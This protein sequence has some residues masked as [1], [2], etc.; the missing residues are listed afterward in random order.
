MLSRRYRDFGR[1]PLIFI[2][3]DTRSKKLN[4]VYQIFKDTLL[5]KY[6]I[7]HIQFNSV[8]TTLLKKALKRI[9][10]IMSKSGSS[11]H[12]KPL[13]QGVLDSIILT[14]QGDVR[15]A[16]INFHFAS[17]KSLYKMKCFIL[18][19]LNEKQ[20]LTFYLDSSVLATELLPPPAVSGKGQKIKS[21]KLKTVGCDE[22]VTILHGVGRV[23]SPK[24]K[25]SFKLS[26]V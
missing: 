25:K 24:C 20:C 19:F 10:E 26:I 6:G 17:Q 8:S 11:E 7:R 2:I 5:S 23:L 14:S 4:I 15:N 3:S 21:K 16:V 13:S 18:K 22:T 1:S 9:C 12:Y